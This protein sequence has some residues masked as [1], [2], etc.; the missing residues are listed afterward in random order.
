[1][2]CIYQAAPAAMLFVTACTAQETVGTDEATIRLLVDQVKE[3]QHRDRDLQER[4]N[5]LEAA[6]ASTQFPAAEP[7]QRATF[8]AM[9]E[10]SRL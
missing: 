8:P 7:A 10:Q 3:L 5:I 4:I 2:S 1:M 6:R 9:P